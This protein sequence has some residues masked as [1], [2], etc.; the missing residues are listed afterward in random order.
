MYREHFKFH[1]MYLANDHTLKIKRLLEGK[2]WQKYY[3]KKAKLDDNIV[4]SQLYPIIS[5]RT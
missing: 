4:R 1:E 5:R 3:F 2:T